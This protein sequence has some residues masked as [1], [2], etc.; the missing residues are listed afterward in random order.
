[1]DT[2]E[3]LLEAAINEFATHGFDGAST[4]RIAESAESHQP[5]INYYFGSKDA[6]WRHA[7]GR[8][9]AELAESTDRIDATAAPAEVLDQAIDR[10]VRF[11]HRR[12]AMHRIMFHEFSSGSERLRWVVDEHTGATFSWFRAIWSEARAAGVTIDID[13]RV[14]FHTFVGAASL[15]PVARAELSM[16]LARDGE[17]ELSDTE[18]VE[19]H[20]EAIRRLLL[21]GLPAGVSPSVAQAAPSKN[22]VNPAG[23]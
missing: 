14:A 1:M 12:P 17:D 19:R 16:Q 2:R 4:R 7:I 23:A 10:F 3:R 5:Q 20:T 6:L 11:A 15:L 21:P 13:A 9:F 22:S 8:L 18:A